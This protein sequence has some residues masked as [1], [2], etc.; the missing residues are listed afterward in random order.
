[1]NKEYLVRHK[2]TGEVGK[3]KNRT[4][5]HVFV[6]WKGSNIAIPYREEWLEKIEEEGERGQPNSNQAADGL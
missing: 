2:T 1:M 6:L 4:K 5:E 3:V